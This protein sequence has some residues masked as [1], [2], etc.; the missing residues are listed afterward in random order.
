VVTWQ[1]EEGISP[2]NRVDVFDVR[3]ATIH[4]D[5]DLTYTYTPG[6][7]NRF[8]HLGHGINSIKDRLDKEIVERTVAKNPFTQH[9]TRGVPLYTTI[10]NLGATTDL[11]A[12]Q[13]QATLTPEELQRIA[14]LQTEIDGLKSN[15]PQAHLQIARAKNEHLT[16]ISGAL[17]AIAKL[18]ATKLAQAQDQLRQAGARYDHASKEAFAGLPIPGV[19]QQEWRAFI[20][21]GEKYLQATK[22]EDYPTTDAACAYCQQPLTPAATALLRSYRDYC[23]N[24]FRTEHDAGQRALDTITGVITA[25]NT[26]HIA[27]AITGITDPTNAGLAQQLQDV[28]QAVHSVQ[29]QVREH[30]PI[31][32]TGML[33]LQALLAPEITKQLADTSA[34][35]TTLQ[36][37]ATE[38]TTALKTRE[39]DLAI[40]QSRVIL[41]GFL[42]EIT[43]Y[44]TQAQWVDKARIQ[45]RRF[46]GIQRS[47]SD[48]AKAASEEALNKNFTHRFEQECKRL[49]APKVI[50]DFPGRQS[51]VT[52]RKT[53]AANHHR[54]NTVLSEGEQ[55]V[56]ALADFLAEISLKPPAPVVFDDPITSLDYVRLQ[57]LVRRIVELS[58]ERQVI[59]FT[60]NIWFTIE[61]LNRFE[62][63]KTECSYYDV[64]R[65]DQLLGIVTKGTHPRADTYSSLKA[66][67]NNNIQAAQQLTGEPQAALIEKGYE[68]L[69]SI[70]EVIVETELLQGVTQRYQP[71]VMMTRLVNIKADRLQAATAIIMPVFED[72]CRFMS[73]HSQ[74][75]ETL[76]VRPTLDDLKAAWKTVQ[77]ALTA[78]KAT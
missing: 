45:T 58:N 34:L 49:R 63:R 2:I 53:V 60:H 32:P 13:T 7:L 3:A 23:N 19:L 55:K 40:L 11:A 35:A 27:D 54:L 12:L 17:T 76:N 70:C 9:F 22:Q 4:V 21:A 30:Q 6:E 43:T 29:Q 16:T 73:G 37:R 39:D 31:D 50:L 75:L 78:Y 42:T 1:D 56:I 68:Y 74:P 18:D 52:R 77:E 41:Q 57:E 5:D 69:R 44:V 51:Q 61:L 64:S 10:E 47:L 8:P 72:C 20:E 59:V 26:T 67:L 28:I 38:R 46:Q 66:R 25:L 14:T 48:T 62:E 71:N 24:T 33:E 65:T 36:A 15:T